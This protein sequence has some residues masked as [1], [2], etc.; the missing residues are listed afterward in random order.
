MGQASVKI[1]VS[2]AGAG[3]VGLLAFVLLEATLPGGRTPDADAALFRFQLSST[4]AMG[5][6]TGVAIVIYVRLSRRWPNDADSAR[7]SNRQK[8]RK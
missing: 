3:V 4:A 2:L 8:L 1:I 5:I 7:A 6:F